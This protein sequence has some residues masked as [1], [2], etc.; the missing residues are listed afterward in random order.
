MEAADGEIPRYLRRYRR[1][2][3]EK[4]V[5]RR[6]DER[7]DRDAIGR[8]HGEDAAVARANEDVSIGRENRTG[9]GVD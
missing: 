5:A 3:V 1:R 4:R 6:R 2:A 8:S 7:G 9:R